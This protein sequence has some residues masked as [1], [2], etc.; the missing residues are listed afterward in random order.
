MK[1][2]IH[3]ALLKRLQGLQLEGFFSA[4]DVGTVSIERP[5]DLLHGDYTTSVAF[6]IAKAMGQSPADVAQKIVEDFVID[7]VQIS[8]MGPYINFSLRDD[9]YKKALADVRKKKDSYGS[10]EIYAGKK[11]LLEH[12][13]PNL[14]KPFHIGH[15]VNNAVGESINQ[16][17]R[18]SGAQ[19]TTISYPSDVSLGIAKAVWGM[20]E[21]YPHLFDEEKDLL[22]TMKAVG[23]AYAYG[24]TQYDQSAEVRHAVREIAHAL[25]AH[26][27]KNP[28]FHLY[29]KGKAL[30]M[31]YFEMMTAMLGSEFSA[32]IYESET[33][34]IGKE[35]VEQNIP[36]IFE[37]SDG[38][39]IFEGEKYGLHTR[40]FIN[41]DGQPTYE[42][43]DLGLLHEKFKRFS[44]DC[45][46]FITDHEQKEYFR[47][48]KK[49]AGLINTA[50]EEK[51]QHLT[52]G[53]LGFR[54]QKVSSRLGNVPLAEDVIATITDVVKEKIAQ[55][56]HSRGTVCAQDIAIGAIKFTILKT[57]LGKNMTFEQKQALSFEGD[58]GPYLQ[59]TH[60]RCKSI[61]VKATVAK[62]ASSQEAY[63]VESRDVVQQVML[64]PE[65]VERAIT[66]RSPHYI[67]SYLL[68]LA[69]AYNR[70]Y[71]KHQIIDKDD[72]AGSS[73]RVGLTDAVA[74]TLKNGLKLLGITAPDEM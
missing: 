25:Y 51:T 49:A 15:L 17:L 32:Y 40:V 67:A 22:S 62:I 12:S 42:A 57:S 10:T 11:I 73:Y 34:K 60:A 39:V 33:G 9:V 59:Y 45:S 13:S 31:T 65:N 37:H 63:D 70:Y 4:F 54:G 35:L 16:L 71:S 55:N 52:H 27:T 72:H 58:S 44:P 38:A 28:Y 48:V 46:I 47:V 29:E 6:A 5:K 30:N 50:W 19:V 43:K 1:T 8:V 74:I 53:R 61:L 64:F 3:D 56:E 68:D 18:V 2:I 36:G 20:H 66:E 69:H 23:N 7:D 14:F 21:K 26:D 24:T 41:K